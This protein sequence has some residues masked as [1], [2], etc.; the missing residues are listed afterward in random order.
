MPGM[1]W[2]APWL[3]TTTIRPRPAARIAGSSARVRRTGPKKLVEKTCSH[4]SIG[5][6]SRQPTAATPALWTS[7]SGAPP[8][9]ISSA[10]AATE[11]GSSRSRRTPTS[12]G[13]PA[14]A[15]VAARRR[16][17]PSSGDRMAASTAHPAR[18]R[19]AAVARPRPR[20]APVTTTRRASA[21]TAPAAPG[22]ACRRRDVGPPG[23]RALPAGPDPGEEGAG[24]AVLLVEAVRVV[25][26][27]LLVRPGA[28]DRGG[29][30]RPAD[31]REPAAVEEEV[32]GVDDHE[33]HEERAEHRPAP[34]D[35]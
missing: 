35:A 26:L 27:G 17:R 3:D 20:E 1:P 33:H 18:C 16:A 30:V 28:G 25:D 31:Q 23:L 32:G 8:A 12:R 34:Q 21:T 11:A 13:S 7:P 5:S 22:A 6:S 2:T 29:R 14:A 24:L 10:A 19:W 9:R 15:P 4:T